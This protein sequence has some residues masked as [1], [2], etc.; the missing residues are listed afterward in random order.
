MCRGITKADRILLAIGRSD[1]SIMVFILTIVRNCC[2]SVVKTFS[3][4]DLWL[5]IS[6]GVV[7]FLSSGLEVCSNHLKCLTAWET[8]IY[9]GN[10][11]PNFSW[12]PSVRL[13]FDYTE[14]RPWN[15]L[16]DNYYYSYYFISVIHNF[17]RVTVYLNV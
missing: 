12:T 8:G 17:R 3:R 6:P 9:F 5:N 16:I 1:S 13:D 11:T 7:N 4:I 10:E 2:L 14:L 15:I